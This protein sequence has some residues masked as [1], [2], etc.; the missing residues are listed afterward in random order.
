MIEESK[1]GKIRNRIW[2]SY[3]VTYSFHSDIGMDAKGAQK[4]G[5]TTYH[6]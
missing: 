1:Y 2:H 3:I 5:N 6:I 4:N